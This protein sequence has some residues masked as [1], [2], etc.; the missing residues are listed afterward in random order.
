[1]ATLQIVIHCLCLYVR[2]EE[3]SIV[4]VLMPATKGHHAEHFARL[5]HPTFTEPGN[6]R[7]LAG[8]ALTLGPASG[9]AQFRTLNP[10]HGREILNLTAATVRS[11]P[12][13]GLKVKPELITGPH[14]RVTA[15]ITLRGGGV[16]HTKAEALWRF[17]NR[18]VEMV[19]AV[20][21]EMEIRD[22]EAPLAWASIG[23]GGDPPLATLSSL[24]DEQP[25]EHV[26]DQLAARTGY[27]LDV[28]HS[29]LTDLKPEEVE[30]HFRAYYDMLEHTPTPD[31]LPHNRQEGPKVHCGSA[32]ALLG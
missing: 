28:F 5:V 13:A 10:Q 19:T 15:R 27:R 9:A 6:A 12:P 3:N 30:H 1:M 16:A 11:K 2:D 25:L 21:W 23:A 7:S 29:T 14:D 4:H 17:D 22:V 31:E 18:W 24:G 20:Y 32:Q 26:R 8:W